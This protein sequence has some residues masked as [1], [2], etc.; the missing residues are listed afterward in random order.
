MISVDKISRVINGNIYG[1]KNFKV[2]GICDIEDG[3]ENYISY[4]S[5]K[6]YS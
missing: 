6:K 5:D 3:K 2:H 4:I 1:N